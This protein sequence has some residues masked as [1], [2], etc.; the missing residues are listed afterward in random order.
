[1]FQKSSLTALSIASYNIVLKFSNKGYAQKELMLTIPAQPI[2]NAF[3]PGLN[4]KTE[5]V[6]AKKNFTNIQLPLYL[7]KTATRTVVLWYV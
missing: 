1:M 4:A 2:Q 7:V 5:G 3:C 6:C